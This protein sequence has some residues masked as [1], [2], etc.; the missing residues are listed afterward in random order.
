MLKCPVYPQAR[1]DIDFTEGQQRLQADSADY[2]I[3]MCFPRITTSVDRRRENRCSASCRRRIP[4][5]WRLLSDLSRR[6][7][8]DSRTGQSDPNRP[9]CSKAYECIRA[10]HLQSSL[11][12]SERAPD[13]ESSQSEVS[14]QPPIF[15]LGQAVRGPS[16]AHKFR[17][18]NN[19]N[20][21]AFGSNEASALKYVERISHART[22]YSEHHR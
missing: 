4:K 15:R 11:S 21:A 6:S 16:E 13:H 5:R 17:T 8:F 10:A 1:L 18:I 7:S 3:G 12:R 9:C 19:C 2:Q 14:N 20:F 22:P